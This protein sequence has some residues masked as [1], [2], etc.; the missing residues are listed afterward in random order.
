MDKFW[1][2]YPLY[3]PKMKYCCPW[4]TPKVYPQKISDCFSRR[5]V[6]VLR[7]RSAHCTSCQSYA[8]RVHWVEI[9]LPYH[10]LN[11]T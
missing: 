9:H 11:A 5:T 1:I 2:F 4:R 10:I 6:W 8:P 3:A 7:R